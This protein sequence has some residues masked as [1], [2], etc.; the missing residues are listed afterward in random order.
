MM[1][2]NNICTFVMPFR[3]DCP[4]RQ[5]NLAFIIN[6][7]ASLKAKIILL[8]ADVQSRADNS[9]FHENVEYICNN[10]YYLTYLRHRSSKD[11]SD[12]ASD[13]RDHYT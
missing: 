7:L 5:R 3:I 1:D 2:L 9:S 6:W 4:E 10:G 8:E 11:T 12:N 13:K